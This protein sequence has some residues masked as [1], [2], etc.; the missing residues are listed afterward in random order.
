[1]QFFAASKNVL[2]TP[3]T[4]S[5]KIEDPYTN[6]LYDINEIL[7]IPEYA[8]TLYFYTKEVITGNSSSRNLLVSDSED[9]TDMLY[10]DGETSTPT[11]SW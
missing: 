3:I 1:L 11:I 7:S 4:Y 5:G 9:D 10:G 8:W 6:E 2:L